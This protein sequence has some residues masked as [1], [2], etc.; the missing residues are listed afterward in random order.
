[1]LSGNRSLADNK[2]FRRIKT[3]YNNT[4]YLELLVALCDKIPLKE[5]FK[6]EDNFVWERIKNF[7]TKKLEE[8]NIKIF[9]KMNTTK[10]EGLFKI[11]FSDMVN[12]EGLTYEDGNKLSIFN[13]FNDKLGLYILYI[14]K[15]ANEATEMT[16]VDNQ[17][18]NVIK[19]FQ[20][21]LVVFLKYYKL[22]KSERFIETLEKIITILLNNYK[23]IDNSIFLKFI[24]VIMDQNG[25]SKLK[26][27]KKKDETETE[28]TYK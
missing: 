27:R 26:S 16:Q 15:T 24:T 19:N 23:K 14:V 18:S 1:M 6:I 2:L 11:L 3:Y 25:K 28:T 5:F 13:E 22:L 7:D 12:E 20:S 4:N 10:N 21:D 17:L 9:H 8:N